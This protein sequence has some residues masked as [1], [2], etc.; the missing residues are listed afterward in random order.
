MEQ[1]ATANA[2]VQA[3]TQALEYGG[4]VVLVDGDSPL[5]ETEGIGALLRY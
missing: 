2:A 5:A 3:I 4:E 1:L